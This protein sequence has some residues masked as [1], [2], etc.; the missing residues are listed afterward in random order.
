MSLVLPTAAFNK[1]TDIGIEVLKK[2]NAKAVFLDIDNTLA[3]H[4]NPEPFDGA[5][6]WTKKVIETGIEIVIIS[7]NFSS[8]VKPF[9]QKFNLPFVSFAQKPFPYSFY[10]AKKKLKN[11]VKNKECVVI[12]DQIFTDIIGA[13][14]LNIKSILVTPS[15]NEETFSFILRRRIERPIR[16]KMSRRKDSDGFIN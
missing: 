10:R 6:D 11:T 9:A 12:G 8:R 5:L 15:I 2:L 7:N 16:Q 4:G 13:N 1:I 14:I 3:H